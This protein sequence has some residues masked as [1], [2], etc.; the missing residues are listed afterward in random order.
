M[1]LIVQIARMSDGKRHITHVSEI[2]GM[3]G[4]VVAMQDIFVYDKIGID[5]GGR[6]LGR[7]RATGVSPKFVE[8][9]KTSGIVVPPN[10]FE[11]SVDA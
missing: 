1:A 11:H 6:V 5:P 7:F 8:R 4:D 3:T 2:T 10:V 9:L